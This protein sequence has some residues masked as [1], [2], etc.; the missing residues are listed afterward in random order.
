[1]TCVLNGQSVSDA[2]ALEQVVLEDDCRPRFSHVVGPTRDR[3][4]VAALHFWPLRNLVETNS[5]FLTLGSASPD[6]SS[7][8]VGS[9][10]NFANERPVPKFEP[11]ANRVDANAPGALGL[12]LSTVMTCSWACDRLQLGYM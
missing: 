6:Q 1:M 9:R 12:C 8:T 5:F 4:N 10:E 3:P 11:A 7:L 2:V